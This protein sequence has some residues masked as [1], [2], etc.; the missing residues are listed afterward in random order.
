ML[1]RRGVTLIELLIGIVML[2]I[3]GMSITKIMSTILNTSSAHITIAN[4][5]GE[6]RNGA[7]LLSQELREVG[8]DTNITT[9]SARTDL[10]GIAA[11]R[12]SFRAIRGM[13]ITCGTPSLTEFRVLKPITG[14]RLPVSTDEF[15]L[16]VENDPNAGFDDQW[17][18]MLVTAIDSNSTC[19]SD[20]A[21]AF[22]LSAAPLTRTSPDVAMALS[23]HRVGGP[24][25]WYERVEYGPFIDGTSGKTFIGV[26]S[27]SLNQTTINPIIGPIPD[28]THFTLLY[29]D[30]AGAVLD[31]ASANP[32]R[33][34]SIGLR[35]TTVTD[36]VSSLAG[37]TAA[38][39]SR[40][41]PM[42]TRVALR[43]TLRP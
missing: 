12:I 6:S 1:N 27:L 9:V 32:L 3:I 37:T 43:N 21:I 7:L 15:L 39:T 33:V 8:Y 24:I 42:V 2:A 13:G 40:Q 38:R 20:P 14:Q 34:R 4:S 41:Y 23:N 26:R 16:F 11:H 18:P 25:R 5:M 30:A 35:I 31:P 28:S 17:L 36:R 29:Y 10:L 19:G 22:T